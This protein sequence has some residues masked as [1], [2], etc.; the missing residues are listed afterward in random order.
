[1][2]CVMRRMLSSAAKKRVPYATIAIAVVL[3]ALMIAAFGALHERRMV[4]IEENF[5]GSGS[6]P[7]AANPAAGVQERKTAAYLAVGLAYFFSANTAADVKAAKAG[8]HVFFAP[9]KG[10]LQCDFTN[11]G[12]AQSACPALI[13]TVSCTDRTTN[14]PATYVDLASQVNSIS[15]AEP[16]DAMDCR[17]SILD[18]VYSM[19][20]TSVLAHA[21]VYVPPGQS[22]DGGA[23]VM[24]AL[25][26]GS[27]ATR[28]IMMLRPAFIR[29]GAS[30]LYYVEYGA[31]GTDGMAYDSWDKTAGANAV[32]Q[33][34]PVTDTSIDQNRT[35][36]AAIVNPRPTDPFSPAPVQVAGAG[37][38]AAAAA[39]KVAIP[40]SRARTPLVCY[41]LSY[42]GPNPAVAPGSMTPVATAYMRAS[43]NTTQ[44]VRDKNGNKILSVSV[45]NALSPKLTISVAG[46]AFS[47]PTLDGSGGLATVT[48]VLDVVIA[49]VSTPERTSVRRFNL[50]N[51][52]AVPSYVPAKGATGCESSADL[53]ALLGVY[54]KSST[55]AIPNMADVALRASSLTAATLS[56]TEVARQDSDRLTSEVPL[57]PGQSLVSAS[58]AFKAVFQFDSNFVVYNTQTGLPVWG[59]STATPKSAPPNGPKPFRLTIGRTDGVLRAFD[60]TLRVNPSAAPFWVSSS[61]A[62][63]ADQAP[64]TAHLSDAGTLIVKGALGAAP[65]WA[66]GMGSYGVA[67]LASCPAASAMYAAVNA[68]ELAQ[69][70]GGAA[71]PWS[72]YNQIGQLEGL[73]W[74]GP[75]G[76]C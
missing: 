53:P 26:R 51:G 29:C 35:P 62:A 76:P 72:H 7:S 48:A 73:V 39:R 44:E 28:L 40:R 47:M 57:L 12:V 11:E 59:T 36:I 54:A 52:V 68:A 15:A 63:P 50:P 69:Y 64:Y 19:S 61:T 49:S 2:I 33:L 31:S 16:A 55:N 4:S 23:P 45:G 42:V 32:L 58:G 67:S 56:V 65:V 1:M 21:Y 5:V 30:R 10:D 24:L 70:Q 34:V 18:S 8:Y 13:D 25:P 66:S 27:F 41:Y 22:A 75:P 38:T 3:L 6:Y 20:K 43:P 46:Q 71:A 17:V 9:T 37:V 74:P 60:D 14:I